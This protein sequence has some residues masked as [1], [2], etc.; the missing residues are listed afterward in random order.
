MQKVRKKK[1]S[2]LK[3]IQPVRIVKIRDGN[4]FVCALP[5][6][7]L[8][9]I[10]GDTIIAKVLRA[11][12]FAHKMRHSTAILQPFLVRRLVFFKVRNEEN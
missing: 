2:G 11:S 4:C 7:F 3:I 9:V 1:S 10:Q 8:G 12:N 5:R 6:R